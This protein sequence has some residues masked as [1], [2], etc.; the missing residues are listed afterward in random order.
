MEKKFPDLLAQIASQWPGEGP[1]RLMFQDEARFGRI[2]DT[3][4]CWCPKPT[5]PLCRAM[6]SQE[7]TYA[8]AAVSVSDGKL[9]SLILPY[10]NSDCMQVFLDEVASRHPDERV[11]MVLD[12]AGW[13]KAK[14]LTIPANLRLLFL[15]PYSPELNPAEHLWDDLREKAF[16]NRVFHSIQALENQL[17]ASLREMELQNERVR[18]IVAWPWIINSLLN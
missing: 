15:P 6:V 11:V 16:C 9:D 14:S 17:A 5:R 13:H 1:L 4:R 12:G 7:Y 18:S 2:S 3:R 8:Y 10:V